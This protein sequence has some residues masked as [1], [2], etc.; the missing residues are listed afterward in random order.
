MACI[1]TGKQSRERG[2]EDGALLRRWRQ[3]RPVALHMWRVRSVFCYQLLIFQ[4]KCD[5]IGKIEGVIDAFRR[6]MS[7]YWYL[8]LYLAYLN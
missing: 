2:G 7:T 6:D 4:K 8:A 5:T 3:K 1:G